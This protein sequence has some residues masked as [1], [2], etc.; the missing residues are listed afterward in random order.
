[1]K[2]GFSC[3]FPAAAALSILVMA[4]AARAQDFSMDDACDASPG[5][6]ESGV[7]TATGSTGAFI[8]PSNGGKC[9]AF[10]ND[11]SS[12]ITSIE[13][14]MFLVPGSTPPIVGVGPV[15]YGCDTIGG[16]IIFPLCDIAFDPSTDIL[17][18]TF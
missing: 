15:T 11:T 17:T 4:P 10:R 5:L 6:I 12:P 16:S 9:T 2:V 8:V 3:L 14:Q 18:F 7:L 1:M 13:F